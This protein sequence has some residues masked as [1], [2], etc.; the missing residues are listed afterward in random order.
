MV[1]R[2]AEMVIMLHQAC[3]MNRMES[4]TKITEMYVHEMA[5]EDYF[6]NIFQ[7]NY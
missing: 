4:R 6:K 2:P 7:Y 5:W 1:C 3:T